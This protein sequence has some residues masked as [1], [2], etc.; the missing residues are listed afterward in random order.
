V[1]TELREDPT[2]AAVLRRAAH[3]QSLAAPPAPEFATI[4]R[5]G[6]GI[7]VGDIR[8]PRVTVPTALNTGENQPADPADPLN[9][10][11]T[12]YGTHVPFEAAKLK[13]LYPSR[14]AYVRKVKRV[15]DELVE[16][17]FI[18]EADAPTL[19]R[20]AEAVDLGT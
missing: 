1:S 9:S 20:N 6:N 10:F 13:T 4:V 19:I 3:A 11:C 14:A 2:P 12:F 7:A 17:G 8:L 15:V 18:L 5:D 16:R